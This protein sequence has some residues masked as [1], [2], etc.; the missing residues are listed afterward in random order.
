GGKSKS[1]SRKGKD[2]AGASGPV[3]ADDVNLAATLPIQA[4]GV[5]VGTGLPSVQL[6]P[7]E[8]RVDGAEFQL[9]HEPERADGANGADGNGR[10]QQDGLEGE[11]ESSQTGRLGD[12]NG[13]AD[14]RAAGPVNQAAE[15]SMHEV[16][17]VMRA[18]RHTDSYCYSYKEPAGCRAAAAAPV[19]G[20]AAP[21]HGEQEAEVIEIDPPARATRKVD[22]LKVL[23]H[24]TRMG[25]KHFAG[26][27]DPLE[28][29]EWRSRLARNFSSSRCPEDYQKDI[30]VHFLEGDAHNWWLALDKRTNAEAWDRLEAKFLD[31]VQGRRTELEDEAVQV[32]RFIRGLR[33]EL[34]TYCSVRTF[35]TVSELVE[36][37][38]LLEV[39]LAD[40]HKQKVKSVVVASSQS[41]DRKRK[42][43]QAE[44]GKTSSGRPVCPKCGRHHGGECWRAMGACLRCGK[45]DHS[46]RDCPRQEQGAGG[47]TRTCHYCGKKG[48]LRKDCPKLA[49]GSSKGRGEG[50]KPD[51]NRGQ[52]SAPRVAL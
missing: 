37:M 13:A 9:E 34:R 8:V 1:R 5:N 19:A 21:V 15:P 27:V 49:A 36:R 47:D 14:G 31:L 20:G 41:G 17:E 11:G 28:A 3:G 22:Y 30:A 45:M 10:Q 25:T 44:E 24:I 33:A 52:T 43:D 18:M 46:A 7:T 2:G 50:N 26:S 4:D 42:R 35:S 48:H 29:D 39:N 32:R 16:L 6:N 40:E 51:Q 12:R 23:E 38:A